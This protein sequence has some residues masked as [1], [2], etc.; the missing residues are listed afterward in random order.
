MSNPRSRLLPFL[1][2]EE[3]VS[4]TAHAR[5]QAGHLLIK[6]DA[7]ILAEILVDVQHTYRQ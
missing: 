6:L 1:S 3:P 5:C 7:Q 2:P 4:Q